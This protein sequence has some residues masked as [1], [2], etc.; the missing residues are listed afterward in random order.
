VSVD[1]VSWVTSDWVWRVLTR[2]STA[3]IFN[4]ARGAS[5]G[6]RLTRLVAFCWIVVHGGETELS[7]NRGEQCSGGLLMVPVRRK[8]RSFNAQH[9]GLRTKGP[10]TEPKGVLFSVC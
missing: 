6:D 7:K 4:G 8:L 3:G 10:G 2:G 5:T 9:A 1:V